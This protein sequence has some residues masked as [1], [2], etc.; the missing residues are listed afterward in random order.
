MKIGQVL[1]VSLL[2]VLLALAAC[3]PQPAAQSPTPTAVATVAPSKTAAPT[4]QAPSRAAWEIQWEKTVDAAKK[5]GRLSLAASTGTALRATVA[6]GFQKA[7]GI[8]VEA[9]SGRGMDFIPKVMAERRAGLYLYDVYVG[10]S[11]PMI[12]TLKPAGAWDPLEPALILPDVTDPNI[13]K[14]LW[15][16]GKLWWIDK[17]HMI[18]APFLYP[19]FPMAVNTNLV[20]QGDIK[21]FQDLLDPKWKGK[22]VINDLTV[23]G[24]GDSFL[25]F[26]NASFGWD[27]LVKLADTKPIVM[28]DQRLMLDWL[29]QGKVAVVV[30][31]LTDVLTEFVNAG[32]PISGLMPQEGTWLGGGVGD[33]SI[34]SKRLHDNAAKVFINWLLTKEGS[35]IFARSAG[36]HSAR[37]DVSTDHL[38]PDQMRQNNVKYI[39]K[40][41]EALLTKQ[42][43][44]MTRAKALFDPLKIK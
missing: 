33:V 30:P 26:T 4:A 42:P 2:L 36:Y 38:R 11:T 5:E 6:E 14:N 28:Q 17:D 16:S 25:A 1:V 29:A 43:E 12:N 22:I 41:D 23:A 37:L 31:P 13:I 27:Y 24:V 15:W 19:N 18:L 32:A 34:F 44:L 39:V 10:G 21:S 9:I 20:K 40:E 8:P 35:T 7:Y 3:T